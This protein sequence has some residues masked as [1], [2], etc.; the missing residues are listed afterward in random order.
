MLQLGTA[1][2][3][4][5]SSSF[6]SFS[7]SSS[8]SASSSSACHS[9]A[10]QIDLRPSTG[11]ATVSTRAAAAQALLAQH[12]GCP[13]RPPQIAASLLAQ[14]EQRHCYFVFFFFFFFFFFFCFFFFCLPFS[15]HADRPAAVHRK[16]YGQHQGCRSTSL[17]GSAPG[18]SNKAPANSRQSISTA[19][20]EALL[21]CFLLPVAS[22][23]SDLVML[24]LLLSA[25][26]IAVVGVYPGVGGRG[27]SP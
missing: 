8:S 6:S 12:L 25:A 20:T 3:L 1:D 5:F 16:C 4:S 19:R 27:G 21:L 13:T 14:P 10:T 23:F 7:S 26:V 15:S 24:G 9:P 2:P 18:R 17:A 22:G 11:S